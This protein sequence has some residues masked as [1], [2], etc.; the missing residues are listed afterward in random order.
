MPCSKKGPAQESNFQIRAA[1]PES[2]WVYARGICLPCT[3]PWANS[4]LINPYSAQMCAKCAALLADALNK[5]GSPVCLRATDSQVWV[6]EQ[7]PVCVWTYLSKLLA[8]TCVAQGVRLG[9]P[10]L[11]SLRRPSSI[12]S[13]HW[14]WVIASRSGSPSPKKNNA[15]VDCRDPF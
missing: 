11:Y 6:V 15:G 13:I 1:S 14:S 3:V 8:V 12:S 4:L 2:P 7:V 10:L 9:S 5:C